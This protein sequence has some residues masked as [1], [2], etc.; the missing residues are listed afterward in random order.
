MRTTRSHFP[1]AALA[2]TLCLLLAG[3]ALA[4][5][6]GP[7]PGYS[8]P[9]VNPGATL[10]D[11]ALMHDDAAVDFDGVNLAAGELGGVPG[12]QGRSGAPVTLLVSLRDQRGYLY[13]DGRR[14]AVTT[15][16]TGKPGYDT[17]TGVFPIMEKQKVHYS[18]RYE[19]ANGRPAPMPFMQRLTDYG[20]ALHQGHVVDGPASHGCVRLPGEFAKQLYSITQRGDIVVISEDPSLES[21]ARAGAD[22]QVALL[23]GA[24]SSLGELRD[25]VLAT[26]QGEPG[27]ETGATPH[28]TSF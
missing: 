3:P 27:A 12:W 21:L 24:S 4:R 14:I 7:D 6:A 10:A 28:N 9:T 17:P 5:Q 18:N 23:L 26:E 11:P 19:G 8:A 13:R 25:T 1:R 16:S 22:A 15:V 20:V 2:A